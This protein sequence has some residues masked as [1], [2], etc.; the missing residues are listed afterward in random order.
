MWENGESLP[1]VT[2][3]PSLCR[4]LGVSA[5]VLLGT[6]G[7][8]IESL[9]EELG[10]QIHRRQGKEREEVLMRVL[11]LLHKEGPADW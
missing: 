2:L 5:D 3:L 11:P 7:I 10:R 8:G 9:A 6:E 4:V 1:D